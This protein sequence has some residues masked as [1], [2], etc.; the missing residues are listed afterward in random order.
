MNLL[1][2]IF[3]KKKIRK[4]EITQDLDQFLKNSNLTTE[5]ILYFKIIRLEIYLTRAKN[6]LKLFLK[7]PVIK[8]I[9]KK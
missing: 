3:G 6:N 4:I 9:R 5:E 8:K 2:K 1:Q 7:P